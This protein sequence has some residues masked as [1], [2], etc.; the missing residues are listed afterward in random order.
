MSEQVAV[1]NQ[2]RPSVA[3]PL[4]LGA[5]GALTGYY[6]S[7]LVKGDFK[8]ADKLVQLDKDTFDREI[9]AHKDDLKDEAK[10]RYDKL[11]NARPDYANGDTELKAFLD[12]NMGEI[13]AET[14]Y[15]NADG[16][17]IKELADAVTEAE[18]AVNVNEN[19]AVKAAQKE[20]NELAENAT[21]E[22]RK[23]ATDK[24]NA[25]KKAAVDENKA[26]KT[27]RK[28]VADAKAERYAKIEKAI[29]EGSDDTLKKELA[30]AKN[31][32]KKINDETLKDFNW[33]DLKKILP[34]AKGWGAVLYGAIGLVVGSIIAKVVANKKNRA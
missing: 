8:G 29:T 18:N 24:L 27:A 32:M 30:E 22:V 28:A 25:A 11:V 5:G 15:K 21:D 12:K 1:N 3:L 23:A 7:P 13:G 19:A 33:K 17:T 26:V 2:A 14:A 34:K 16:K 20:F 31:F 4:V 6:L 9:A 10:A